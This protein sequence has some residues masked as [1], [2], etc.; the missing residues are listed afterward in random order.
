MGQEGEDRRRQAEKTLRYKIES[1]RKHSRIL[2]PHEKIDP[3][4]HW[5]VY[6]GDDPGGAD[7]S[8]RRNWL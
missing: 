3:Y 5:H 6:A 8:Q 4:R 2:E 7:L 1:L